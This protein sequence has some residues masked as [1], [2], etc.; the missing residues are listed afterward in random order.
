M[1]I[2]SLGCPSLLDHLK[3]TRDAA[4]FMPDQPSI[5]RVFEQCVTA[6]KSGQMIE[7]ESRQD[8]EFHFQNWF[9]ASLSAT[10]LNHEQGGRNT[11]PDFRMVA[12]TEGYEVKGLAYPGRELNYDC[13]SQA[14][15]GEHNGRTI[16]Y[17]FGRYPAEPDGKRYPVLDLVVCHGDFLNAHHDYV[18]KNKSVR[19]FGSYG[20]ILIRDRKMYVAPT[21]FGVVDGVAHHATLII[22]SGT[23]APK[24]FGCVGDIVRCEAAQLIVGYRFDLRTNTLT[25]ETVPNPGADREHSF[26]AWRLKGESSEVVRLRTRAA[27]EAKIK[28]VTDED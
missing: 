6:R 18:H 4:L 24:G 16:Y 28:V 2:A 22:P 13:N 3:S 11:Y 20:D 9:Q 15:S 23:T 21:P 10:G 26:R 25:A 8:K 17:V 14:P 5:F 12:S 19:G 7:R 1:L 27:K